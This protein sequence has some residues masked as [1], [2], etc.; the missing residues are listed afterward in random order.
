MKILLSADPFLPVPPEHYGGIE[1]V[2]AG[3]VAEYR[4]QGHQVALLSHPDS[5][6]VCDLSLSWS[7]QP[8][9]A[10]LIQHSKDVTG[11]IHQFQ[12]DIWH[13]FS[14]LA[15]MSGVAMKKLP[16]IMSYQRKT[17]G[18]TV[19][20]AA[21]LFHPLHF[22]GCSEHI[23]QQGR[24]AGGSW[25][26]IPN[27]VDC[28]HLTFS[29]VVPPDAPLAF[30]SRLEEIKG[31]H[32]AIEIAKKCSRKLIIAGNRP[33]GAQHNEYWNRNIAPHLD[34]DQ[35]EYMG[36]VNDDQKNTLL[37]SAAAMLVP[38]QWDEPFGIVF[39]EALA[40]GTPVISCPR[41]ALPE[42][43]TPG[44]HGFLI[45]SIEEGVE[46]VYQLDSISRKAC[47]EQAE[48]NF[49]RPV[50]ARKYLELYQGVIA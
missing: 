38:I 48:A 6:C 50:V 18:N 41:G 23:C 26:A 5:S 43:I 12:P 37:G 2:I 20:W 36:P 10:S 8:G 49:S 7:G 3:L 30:L 15:Y 1:R 27:F 17:G 45:R 42:I 32:W 14:R 28:D 39:A 44:E 40:C 29:P 35:I 33:E 34:S 22:T 19:R 47:R 31:V 13:S 46:A 16:K 24:L 4:D 9:K 21:R 25:T 11:A